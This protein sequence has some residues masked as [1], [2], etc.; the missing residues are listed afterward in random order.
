MEFPDSEATTRALLMRAWLERAADHVQQRAAEAASNHDG[1]YESPEA[2]GTFTGTGYGRGAGQSPKTNKP[3]VG[4]KWTPISKKHTEHVAQ[5]GPVEIVDKFTVAEAYATA[6]VEN[7][8]AKVASRR[9][10][11]SQRGPGHGLR[12]RGL[13]RGQ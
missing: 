2:K 7:G 9:F 4:G 1:G 12:S 11:S 13:W 6:S 10:G 5:L 8:K 3:S